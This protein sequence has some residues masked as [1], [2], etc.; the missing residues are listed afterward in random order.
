MLKLA[1][2]EDL[3]DTPFTKSIQ[4]EILSFVQNRMELQEAYD[5]Q[6]SE[7]SE[8]LDECDYLLKKN[9]LGSL[10]DD[11]DQYQN[12]PK[13]QII[14]NVFQNAGLKLQK[15]STGEYD[16]LKK[17]CESMEQLLE[18]CRDIEKGLIRQ[19]E[20][21][22][23]KIEELL[24]EIHS[25]NDYIRR[26]EDS[27]KE[28][29]SELD[30]KKSMFI[31]VEMKTLELETKLYESNL[32]NK[33]EVS[34]MRQ[35]NSKIVSELKA[36][37]VESTSRLE[38]LEMANKTLGL[39]V[40]DMESELELAEKNSKFVDLEM[41]KKDMEINKLDAR[42]NLLK[43]EIENGL[44]SAQSEK[45]DLNKM[46]EDLNKKLMTKSPASVRL[47][48][49]DL[50]LQDIGED[51]GTALEKQANVWDEDQS[52]KSQ[53]KDSGYMQK[54]TVDHGAFRSKSDSG[55]GSEG[56][57]WRE[58]LNS[59]DSAS[60]DTDK[61]LAS[62]KEINGVALNQS[63]LLPV[64]KPVFEVEENIFT[65]QVQKIHARLELAKNQFE[66]LITPEKSKL[67]LGLS[68]FTANSSR[69]KPPLSMI[70]NQF[71]K[72]VFPIQPPTAKKLPE[73]RFCVTENVFH[74]M[75][76]PSSTLSPG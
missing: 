37:E 30:G 56:H 13:P 50:T 55:Q 43:Q 69:A 42:V 68:L 52:Q 9:N 71:Q 7:H 39:R 44:V 35:K 16:M 23:E 31:T 73:L 28:I 76:L 74:T 64:S 24:R 75:V 40:A 61:L 11:F 1:T 53:P 21:S 8:L 10:K 57:G 62:Q 72:I 19:V 2:E 3:I 67:E 63:Q 48:H 32:R 29:S 41:K 58:R 36:S 5:D 12:L 18:E 59:G 65:I 66:I 60:G 34:G 47:H 4:G 25:K 20:T 15:F 38:Q 51:L 33:K 27:N 26:M 22:T 17:E 70:F 54:E 14:R 49:R 46:I 6:R 45:S